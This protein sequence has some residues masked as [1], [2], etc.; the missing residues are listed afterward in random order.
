M[1]SIIANDIN[2]ITPIHP[3]LNDNDSDL[4]LKK[5][6]INTLNQHLSNLQLIYE[7]YICLDDNEFDVSSIILVL[8]KIS[9]G[10]DNVELFSDILTD[11][12]GYPVGGLGF[13][14]GKILINTYIKQI[15]ESKSR[16]VLD[17][18]LDTV[19][20]K[21]IHRGIGYKLYLELYLELINTT[22]IKIHFLQNEL[23][24][25]N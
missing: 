6:I 20:S 19:E 21:L 9:T 15:C 1:N 24:K 17:P 16:S 11:H 22:Q 2:E 5:K 14:T 18:E 25:F 13:H 4:L 8:N 7:L 3:I 10:I 12:P 23:K